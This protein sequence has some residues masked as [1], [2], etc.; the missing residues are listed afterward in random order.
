MVHPSKTVAVI[1]GGMVG[2]C[3]ARYLQRDG[4]NVIVLDPNEP[5]DGASF[6]NAGC[7]NPSSLVPI[8]GPD[9]FKQVPGYLMDPL[10]PLSI[11]WSYLL[12][13]T[14]WL[15]RYG[16][17]GVPEKIKH[18]SLALKSI[19]SRSLEALMP[20]VDDCGAHDLV[21]RD[22]ILIVYRSGQSVASDSRGWNLRREHGIHWEE[23]DRDAVRDF[24][25]NLTRDIQFG[26]FVPG[27]GH[28]V[29]P[30]A[31][32]KEI[33]RHVVQSGGQ[34][35]KVRATDFLFN[36]DKL[37]AVLTD[38]GPIAVDM[39]VVAA[40]AH[41]KALARAA[42]NSVPLESERGYHVMIKAPEVRPRVPTTDS[43][44]KFVVTPMQE[45]VRVA[46]TVE[47]AGLDAKP[48]WKRAQILL[49]RIGG[50]YPA[51]GKTYRPDDFTVWM[52]HRPSLPDSLPVIGRSKRSA[53]VIYAFGH[54]H[55]GMTAAPYTGVIIAALAAGRPSPVDLTPF[56]PDRF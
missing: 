14:P 48:N 7:F 44:H 53:D 51:L 15:I 20:L 27:N 3:I 21:R 42:G 18:Q 5:G 55:V 40:G 46:G 29:N 24:D 43:D 16:L 45:G 30:G 28:T 12:Q 49:N 6:G 17:A 8:A 23:L 47:L 34:Y 37:Q 26:K 38:H 36:G 39:A 11:R 9:T 31:L 54:Q 10:G 19:L 32:V 52:G 2:A 4:H 22:G 35:R 25:P 13:V 50:L 41:S 1:G 56:Q 33:V